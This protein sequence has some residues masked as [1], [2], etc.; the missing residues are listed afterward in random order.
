MERTVLAKWREQ[1][2]RGDEEERTDCNEKRRK[3]SVKICAEI[4][5]IG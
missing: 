1:G 2:S 5:N 3:E 4:K